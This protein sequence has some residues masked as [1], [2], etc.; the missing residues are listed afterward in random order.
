MK[1]REIFRITALLVVAAHLPVQA[2][3][4]SLPKISGFVNARYSYSSDDNVAHGFDIRRVRL[5]ASGE[6]TSKLD[7][8]VQAEYE[9]S[10]KIIDAYVRWKIAKPFNIQIG[11]FKVPYSQETLYG[12]TSWLTIENPTVVSKL[13]GYQDLSGLNVN[14]RDIGVQLYGDLLPSKNGFSYVSYKVG[15]FNGNGINTKDNNNK[16]DFAGLLYIRP[17]K[18]LTLTGGHYQGHYGKLHEEHV[19]IRT[20]AGAEWKDG[21][22]TVRSEYIHGNTAGQKS[23]GVYAL[24]GVQVSKYV[25]PVISYDYFKPDKDGREEQHNYQIGVNVTPIKRV[26]IQAAYTYQKHLVGKDVNLAEVQG[27]LEF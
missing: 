4:I 23:D 25:Q 24:A 11:E 16:K 9:S 10:V 20:S 17:I 8:K 26:R 13:N 5:A 1:K 3:K 21:T 15:V 19:R 22:L 6:V 18:Q 14:G 12:P 2:Q 27:F 7:Y